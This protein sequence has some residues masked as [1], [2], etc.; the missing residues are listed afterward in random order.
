MGNK[1]Q[2]V[3]DQNDFKNLREKSSPTLESLFKKI[4][5]HTISISEGILEEYLSQLRHISDLACS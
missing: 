2:R 5:S 4:F 3:N 1:F